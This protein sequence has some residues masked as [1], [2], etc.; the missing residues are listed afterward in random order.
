LFYTLHGDG[1]RL[2]A[3]IGV[4]AVSDYWY[5]EACCDATREADSES[6]LQG[7]NCCKGGRRNGR[8]LR[9]IPQRPMKIRESELFARRALKNQGYSVSRGKNILGS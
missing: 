2:S 8:R 5:D 1:N 4:S 9:G 7:P 6:G 3:S